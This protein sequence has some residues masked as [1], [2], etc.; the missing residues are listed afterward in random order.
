[1]KFLDECP[2][3]ETLI[4][5][6]KVNG[7][8]LEELYIVNNDNSLNLSI[9]KY[10]PELKSLYTIFKNDEIDS[11]KEILNSCHYLESIRVWCD[12]EYLNEKEF[13][14]ILAKYSSKSFYELRMY[15]VYDAPSEIFPEELEEFFINWK[16]RIPLSFII[17][18]YCVKSFEG[19]KENMEVI[20]KYKKLGVI[21]NFGTEWF[22]EEWSYPWLFFYDIFTAR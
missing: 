8:N 2:K 22:G 3:V 18:G 21:K 19:K 9:A 5:F 15:Y 7:K 16:D 4:N 6:L 12:G 14:E 13:L 11:L 20:E 10:C 1:L 17:K